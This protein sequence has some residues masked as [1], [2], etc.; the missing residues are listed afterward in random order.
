VSLLSTPQ[1]GRKYT[2]INYKERQMTYHELVSDGQVYSKTL[3]KK[4]KK[5]SLFSFSD[6]K[7]IRE[8][9]IKKKTLQSSRNT[10]CQK[11]KI[12]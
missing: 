9:E 2:S 3:K 1:Y 11:N 10:T 5:L 7:F 6:Q 4:K 8:V 12:K